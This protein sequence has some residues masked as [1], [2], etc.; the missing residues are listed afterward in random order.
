MESSINT[1]KLI[2]LPKIE[3]SKGN[4]TPISN[5]VEIPFD[6]K[7]VYYLYD[8]PGGETRGGHAHK[9]LEQFIVAAAGSFDI[10]LNNGKERKTV[11][12]NTADYGLYIPRMVWRELANF[13]TGAICLVLASYEYDE[14]EYI[15]NFDEFL[16]MVKD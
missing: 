6:V 11:K 3:N 15:R 9:K 14:E 13:S 7:R 16:E 10:I 5:G 12:L 8:V 2:K 1:C 4:L